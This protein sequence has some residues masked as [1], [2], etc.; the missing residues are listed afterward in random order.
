M[1]DTKIS[2]LPAASS[3]VS[4]M[5]FEVNDSGTSKK[6][7][8]DQIRDFKC[9][10]Y[11]ARVTQSSTSDPVAVVINN[12][13]GTTVTWTRTGGGYGR[14]TFGSAILAA[15]KT[16]VLHSLRGPGGYTDPKISSQQ[17]AST[18]VIDFGAFRPS[19]QTAEDGWVMDVVICIY[20]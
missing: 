18:T 19:D 2:E 9:L 6:V 12:T 3:V 20:P 16:T 7:T 4:A 15:G 13:T 10:E 5:E 8:S 11:S 1:A 14:C 17:Q